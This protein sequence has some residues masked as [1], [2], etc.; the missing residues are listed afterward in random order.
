MSIEQKA[1]LVIDRLLAHPTSNPRLQ[2]SVESS[3]VQ[4]KSIIDS[5]KVNY[6]VR[7]KALIPSWYVKQELEDRGIAG[8]CIWKYAIGY[9]DGDNSSYFDY[10]IFMA[11][12]NGDDVVLV[13]SLH[14]PSQWLPEP[15]PMYLEKDG[16]LNPDL[17][18]ALEKMDWP[19]PIPSDED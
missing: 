19:K 16:V 14:Y 5:H 4:L 15:K 11:V 2:E 3:L 17:V 9:N 1:K 10:A 8:R 12:K 7:G 18:D 13:T 6:G